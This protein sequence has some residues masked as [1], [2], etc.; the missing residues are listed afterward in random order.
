MKR[1]KDVSKNKTVL[2]ISDTQAPFS[3]PDALKFI[4]Y[5]KLSFNP[6]TWVHVGDEIDAHAIST[7]WAAN[8]DGLSP[9]YELIAAIDWLQQLYEIVPKC[10]VCTSNHMDRIAN[11]AS[12]ARLPS[13][14]LKSI[15]DILDAP[16][17][18]KWA[19]RWVFDNV[20][21]MHGECYSGQMGAL[22]AAVDNRMNTVIGHIHTAGGVQYTSNFNETIFGMNVGCLIDKDQYA[23]NY[24]KKHG[25]KPTLG[26]GLIMNGIPHFLPMILD[27]RGRWIGSL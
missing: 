14:C 4:E 16:N 8:P 26:M 9:K 6:D 10:Y 1:N 27:K 21:Y 12:L 20:A 25:K 13:A 7:R 3:H 11:A 5:C 17:G 2:I 19:D 18:W 24:G 15:N 22:K 23:F